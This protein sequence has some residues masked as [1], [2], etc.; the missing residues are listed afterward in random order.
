[1]IKDI[2][3]KSKQISQTHAAESG[4]IIKVKASVILVGAILCS[5]KFISASFCVRNKMSLHD[6]SPRAYVC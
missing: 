5:Q 1:M 6:F 2:K 3:V 4:A